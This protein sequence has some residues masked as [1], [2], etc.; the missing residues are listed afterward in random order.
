MPELHDMHPDFPP[1][2]PDPWLY[3]PPPPMFPPPPHL[4]PPFPHVLEPLPFDAPPIA[5]LGHPGG[6]ERRSSLGASFAVPKKTRVFPSADNKPRAVSGGLVTGAY[7]GSPTPSSV[8]STRLGGMASSSTR[9]P[10]IQPHDSSSQHR[11]TTPPL[12]SPTRPHLPV[13]QMLKRQF[14]NARAQAPSES[15]IVV[16]VFEI[17]SHMLDKRCAESIPSNS[18]STSTEGNNNKTKYTFSVD[19]VALRRG[20]LAA[21]SSAGSSVALYLFSLARNK[22]ITS[23]VMLYQMKIFIEGTRLL[24]GNGLRS[25][26]HI[27]IMAAL[28]PEKLERKPTVTIIMEG[29]QEDF[30]GGFAMICLRRTGPQPPRWNG[31]YR[32]PPPP[33]QPSARRHSAPALPPAI[34]TVPAK[35]SQ[36]DDLR[37]N[38]SRTGEPLTPPPSAT[39]NTEP[40]NDLPEDVEIGDQ[41]VKLTCPLSLTRIVVPGKGRNCKHVQCFD[42]ETFTK[43]YR[44]SAKWKCGV[45]ND[46]IEKSDLTVSEPF[47]HLLATYPTADRCVV[48][49]DGT[50]TA[51]IP[52]AT[53]NK[54]RR[55]ED[56]PQVVDLMDS[57]DDDEHHHQPQSQQRQ[58]PHARSS[59][60]KEGTPL[61]IPSPHPHHQ[62]PK[63]ARQDLPRTPNG[64]TPPHMS[65]GDDRQT[66]NSNNNDGTRA[67]GGDRHGGRN[68]RD[69]PAGGLVAWRA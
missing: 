46:V 50:H 6:P 8:S 68:I 17:A 1:D 24:P 41:I 38:S 43:L 36:S 60:D 28:N 16:P 35:R 49:S 48:R 55:Q 58:Q 11:P 30:S 59:A 7:S 52:E 63:R 26:V 51:H 32:F 37:S 9:S 65:S 56:E 29:K 5:E 69:V 10:T 54:R 33:T 23:D 2:M 20:M 44:V 27:N 64:S 14:E 31:G 39:V 57:D 62:A 45:C 13:S 3:G 15:E 12:T 42:L 67:G 47:L 53:S 40:G 4:M 22:L 19:S 34:S 66:N 25:G 21:R 18:S 61:S